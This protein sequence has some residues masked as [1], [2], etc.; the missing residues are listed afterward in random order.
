MNERRQQWVDIAKGIAIMAIVL[1]HTKYDFTDTPLLPLKNLL[2]GIWPVPVF[3][4]IGGFFLSNERL[5]Q[6][7]PFV[8]RKVRQ[9]Y[10]PT[11]VFYL[12]A[13][14]LHNVFIHIG[15]YDL[16]MAYDGQYISL[17]TWRDYAIHSLLAFFMADSELIVAPMWFVC[18][19]FAALCL[20]S[21]I[22]AILRRF[23]T[24]ERTLLYIQGATLFVIALI[25]TMVSDAY[26]IHLPRY[27]QTPMALWTIYVGMVMM[28]YKRLTFTNSPLF[29]LSCGV[30]YLTTI[31]ACNIQSSILLYTLC[32]SAACYALCYLSKIISAHAQ[33]A[34][35][36]LAFVGRDSFYIMTLHCFGFKVF[37]LL[38]NTIAQQHLDL[39]ELIAPTANSLPFLLGYLFFGTFIPLLCIHSFRTVYRKI[40]L[41]HAGFG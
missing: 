11:L 13:T 12:L 9:L 24:E 29:V 38:L 17:Y 22:T 23:I 2:A 27:Q 40:K 20:L 6:P 41:L 5:A 25:W 26:Q 31:S 14:L 8:R 39:A 21:A 37:T 15:F 34:A 16:T 19:L 3:F 28:R 10:L 33:L 32:T 4:M 1:W 7:L 18:V 35:G 30:V 36:I